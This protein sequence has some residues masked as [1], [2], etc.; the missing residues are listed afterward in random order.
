MYLCHILV[1]PV[2][3]HTLHTNCDRLLDMS[4]Y[5]ILLRHILGVHVLMFRL[6]EMCFSYLT[7]VLNVSLIYSHPLP[8]RHLLVVELAHNLLKKNGEEGL[9]LKTDSYALQTNIHFPTD[10]SLLCDSLR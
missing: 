3:R 1:L 5:L 6:E 4:N 8:E 7:I 2:I 10:L 9:Y